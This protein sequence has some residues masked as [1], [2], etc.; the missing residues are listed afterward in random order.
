[1]SAVPAIG[2]YPDAADDYILY[3]SVIIERIHVL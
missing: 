2:T 3:Q 1:M